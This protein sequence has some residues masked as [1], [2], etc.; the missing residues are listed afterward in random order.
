MKKSIYLSF[1]LVLI[2]FI[3]I[4]LSSLSLAEENYIDEEI[5]IL[6]N[7]DAVV[8]GVTNVEL[9]SDL[10]IDG[11]KID[12][13][14]SELTS[15]VGKQWLVDYGS[16]IVFS[17]S[18]IK[19]L[20]PSNVKVE[21]IETNSKINIENFNG[22]TRL[23]FIGEDN[24]LDIKIKYSFIEVQYDSNWVYWIILVVIV[25][26]VA[27][28]FNK[29]K[30]NLKTKQE[31]VTKKEHEEKQ[32]NKQKLDGIKM[33]LNETQLKIVD[34]LL[35]QKGE[36]KQT[37]LRHLT[38]IPKASL[39][40]NLELMSQKNIISKFYNGVSNYIKIHPSLYEE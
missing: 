1:L 5:E 4:M 34:A 31:K 24:V 40:R 10:K 36:C 14:T 27:I 23:T 6:E 22:K 13:V 33:T 15:K 3:T 7:G 29:K 11:D 8:N 19:I 18:I 39:S 30:K 2:L 9:F 38:G 32:I 20:F 16:E 37:K 35:D 12:G 21:D 28:L 17:N 25:V 26:L